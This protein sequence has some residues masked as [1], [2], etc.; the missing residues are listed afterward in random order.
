MTTIVFSFEGGDVKSSIIQRGTQR[1]RRGK[2]LDKFGQVLGGSA[3]D[4]LITETSYFV[5]NS[6]MWGSSAVV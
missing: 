6:V 1:L 2:D 3:S 4:D 5:F